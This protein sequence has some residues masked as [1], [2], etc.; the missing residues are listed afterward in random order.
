MCRAEH[1]WRCVSLYAQPIAD[2]RS[3]PLF[4][5]ALRVCRPKNAFALMRVL[6]EALG[7]SYIE[8]ALDSYVLR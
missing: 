8:T 3:D 5:F 4:R 7:R 2:L 6:A 1:G